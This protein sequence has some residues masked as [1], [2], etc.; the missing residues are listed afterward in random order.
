MEPYV[1]LVRP[2]YA[3]NLGSVA[4]VMANFG[5]EEL[6]LVDPEAPVDDEAFRMAV[7]AGGVLRSAKAYPTL[8]SAVDDSLFVVGTSGRLNASEG[9]HARN[10]VTPKEMGRRLR[11]AIEAGHR[12]ALV[13]GREDSGLLV[14][15]LHQCDLMVT[16]PTSPSYPIMNLSHSVSI[17]LY[18]AH[19]ALH[20]GPRYAEPEM[21]GEVERSTFSA[22]FSNLL[23]AIGW[24]ERKRPQAEVLWRRMIARGGLTQW[25]FYVLM[26]VLKRAAR[27]AR[28]GGAKGPKEGIER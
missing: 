10:P 2:K 9:N 5:F 12:P 22:Q 20:G 11:E 25:E 27:A 15:E 28:A 3:G 8:E 18:E 23:D 17:L 1:V 6:R 26:G 7:H 16:I 19:L 14:P 13:F 24:P 4:R 21:T